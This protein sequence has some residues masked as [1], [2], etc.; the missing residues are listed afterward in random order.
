MKKQGSSK[1]LDLIT[2]TTKLVVKRNGLISD[3]VTLLYFKGLFTEMILRFS[4]SLIIFRNESLEGTPD[5]KKIFFEFYDL[6]KDQIKSLLDSKEL[7]IIEKEL[8]HKR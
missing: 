6:Y 4:C 1:S 2:E 3:M 5:S 7:E 8:D